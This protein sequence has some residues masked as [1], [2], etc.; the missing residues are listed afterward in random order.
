MLWSS[1]LMVVVVS[2]LT[3]AAVDIVA[4]TCKEVS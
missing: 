2:G 1:S 4:V 3:V